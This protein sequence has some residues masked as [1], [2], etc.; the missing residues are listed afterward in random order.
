MFP[1]VYIELYRSPQQISKNLDKFKILYLVK[2]L[3][4]QIPIQIN[5][6][7]N[8]SFKEL[9]IEK[10]LPQLFFSVKYGKS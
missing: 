10:I 9:K 4:Y 3:F 8:P 2:Y 6:S 7:K 5:G 1:N